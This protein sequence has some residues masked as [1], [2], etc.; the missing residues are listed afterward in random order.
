VP[1]FYNRDAYLF[2][3]DPAEDLNLKLDY[4]FGLFYDVEN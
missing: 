1:D 2:K 3:F 4:D